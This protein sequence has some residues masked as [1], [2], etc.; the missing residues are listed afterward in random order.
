VKLARWVARVVGK[1][2]VQVRFLF[3]SR[4]PECRNLLC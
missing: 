3:H 2:R 1:G 4:S